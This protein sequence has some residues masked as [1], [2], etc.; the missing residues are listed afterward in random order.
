MNTDDSRI[1][2]R[3]QRLTTGLL[4]EKRLG[5]WRPEL[6]DELY[7]TSLEL[8]QRGLKKS[9]QYRN[10]ILRADQQAWWLVGL[11]RLSSPDLPPP[12]SSKEIERIATL[13][14]HQK[15]A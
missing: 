13:S 12:G 3:F 9:P 5:R 4:A 8:E 1:I 15:A 2:A 6:I 10:V 7:R 14:A 11:A